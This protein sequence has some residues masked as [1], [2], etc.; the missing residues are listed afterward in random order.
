[1][2]ISANTKLAT[3]EKLR[4]IA[5]GGAGAMGRYA[6]RTISRLDSASRITVADID[7]ARAE[8]VSEEV[9]SPCEPM[10]L[11]ATDPIAMREAFADHDVVINTMGPFAKFARAI[12]DAAI[13]SNCHYLDIGDDWQS[14]VESF[15]FEAKARDRGLHVVIGLG[16]SPGVTN[17][18]AVVATERLDTVDS[19]YTGWKLAAAVVEDEP[20]YPPTS[21]ASA[22]V[23]HWLI[24]CS[25]EIKVWK[26][27]ALADEVPVKEVAFNFPGIGPVTAYTMGHPEPLTLPRTF[28][29]IR[30]SVNLQS[31]PAWIFEHL[32]GVAAQY[33]AGKVNLEQGAK[34]LEN[35]TPPSER[36]PRDPLP[37]EWAV[38]Q[39][40]K[41]GQAHAVAVYPS[42]HPAGKMGANTGIP[43]AIG[44][45]LLRR[46]AIKDVGV[47][48]PES[49]IDV[50][51][52]F[53][54]LAQLTDP[55][56][57]SLDDILVI[58]EAAQ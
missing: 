27:G 38:A 28:P 56:F 10:Q 1:M 11:D 26:D 13:D 55:S 20:D 46:G 52:F 33:D 15:E 40:K 32:R 17:L 39:G 42:K 5:V 45:E 35:P 4:V 31:G 8:Q 30:E 21:H 36:S 57:S 29:D 22:A 12:L 7:F 24:Q 44:V 58:E 49:A 54:L 19:L 41:N 3:S 6:V 14:T 2:A 9:G 34:L 16:S 53:E 51:Q 23:E 48:A 47:H 25:G 18:C 50:D 37:V 43:L